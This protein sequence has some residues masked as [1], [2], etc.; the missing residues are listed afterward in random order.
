MNRSMFLQFCRLFVA[1][2]ALG[3]LFAFAQPPDRGG[4]G[5]FGGAF[6]GGGGL[7]GLV[8]REDVQQ[9]IQLVDEQLDKV[10]E[11]GQDSFETMREEIRGVWE[12][13]RDLSEDER[14][15]RFRSKMAEL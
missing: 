7:V 4:P 9:E 12:E 8:M 2:A 1:V 5:G 10:T 15:E 14:R 6:G 3:T 11:I 13:T